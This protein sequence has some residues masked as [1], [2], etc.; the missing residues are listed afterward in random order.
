MLL[1]SVNAAIGMMVMSAVLNTAAAQE[2]CGFPSR[3]ARQPWSAAEFYKQNPNPGPRREIAIVAEVIKGNVP[4]VLRRFIPVSFSTTYRGE[5][6][7][8]EID[9]MPDYLMIGTNQDAVRAPL[10]N[11]AAQYLASEMGLVMPTKFLVDLIYNE[12]A[13]QLLPQPTDWYK[14]PG[15]MQY[16]PNYLMFH[17][18][19]ER[20]LSGRRGLIAGHKKDVVATNLLDRAPKAVAIYGW[21]RPGNKPI[22]PIGTPHGYDYEDYSHGIRFLGPELR[23]HQGKQVSVVELAKALKDPELGA[24]LNG[25]QKLNDVRA[26][27]TC[28]PEFARALGVPLAQCPPQPRSCGL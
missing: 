10:T 7:V 5:A 16:G 1:K 4:E 23:I 15:K 9:V 28:S 25:G 17:E 20:Q 19:I 21:Q 14:Y 8:F 24:I 3:S 27:R 13:V 6:A 12:A 22:Q 18:T 2:I 11:Y 26:A